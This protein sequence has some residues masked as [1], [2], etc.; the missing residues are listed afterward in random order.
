MRNI[1]FFAEPHD[2]DSNLHT[3]QMLQILKWQTIL[4]PVHQEQNMWLS[5]VLDAVI[6]GGA[7]LSIAV[8]LLFRRAWKLVDCLSFS[9][10]SKPVHLAWNAMFI[11][12]LTSRLEESL[13]TCDSWLIN[14]HWWTWSKTTSPLGF[15]ALVLFC[16]FYNFLS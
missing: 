13:W 6:Q 15:G 16:I 11:R 2:S 5:Q 14:Y 1:R 9:H 7:T 10:S 4:F 3:L 8:K 12:A